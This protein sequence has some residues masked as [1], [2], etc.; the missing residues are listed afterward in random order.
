M[1]ENGNGNGSTAENLVLL[2]DIIKEQSQTI[3]TLTEQFKDAPRAQTQQPIYYG[4]TPQAT[5]QPE[6]PNYALFIM[7]A[8]GLYFFVY[9]RR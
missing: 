3:K 8:L 4:T 6:P 5:A 7:I 2:N 1:A 9:K